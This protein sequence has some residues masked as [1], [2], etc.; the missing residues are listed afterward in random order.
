MLRE[1]VE[2]FHAA[3]ADRISALSLAGPAGNGDSEERQFRVAAGYGAMIEF[4]RGGLDPE[5]VDVRT[6]T[7]AQVLRWKSGSVVLDAT[8]ATGAELEPFQARAAIVAIP[9]AVLR[10]KALRFDPP[11]SGEGEG[12]RPAGDRAGLQDHPAVPGVLLGEERPAAQ[13]HPCAPRRGPGLVDAASGAS[14]PAHGMGGRA[15]GGVAAGA[16]RS[17]AG[18]PDPGLRRPRLRSDPPRHRRSARLVALLR[19]VRRP[20]QPRRLRRTSAWADSRR[21]KCSR[22]RCRAPFSS[23]AT[24]W[25]RRRSARSRP[26]SSRAARRDGTPPA[27]SPGGPAGWFRHNNPAA[28]RSAIQMRLLLAFVLVGGVAQEGDRYVIDVPRAGSPPRWAPWSSFGVRPRPYDR[29]PG[30]QGELVS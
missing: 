3:H 24:R 8:S 2:G 7:V 13:F 25:M 5:R 26:R 10:A 20:L 30:L 28:H 14:A 17:R 27:P 4:L 18:R 16:R 29:D 23:P 21:R 22:V 12:G 15:A 11:A 9:H 1:F 6:G 19:L